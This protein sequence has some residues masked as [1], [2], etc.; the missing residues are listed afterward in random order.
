[1]IP[2]VPRHRSPPLKERWQ[3]ALSAR[4]EA[5][6]RLA[7]WVSVEVVKGGWAARWP[8][9]LDAL[10]CHAGCRAEPRPARVPRLVEVAQAVD[11]ERPIELEVLSAATRSLP[12]ARASRRR[13]DRR[14]RAWPR[15]PSTPPSETRAAVPRPRPAGARPRSAR[16]PRSARLH[17]LPEHRRQGV[18]KEPIENATALLGADEVLVH[19]W[20]TQCFAHRS[21]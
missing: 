20:G 21:S 8:L 12:P 6:L 15:G 14:L 11:P 10:T 7:S 5:E 18:A 13:S 3:S 4:R 9:L 17:L 2:R 19:L 16:D 1:M